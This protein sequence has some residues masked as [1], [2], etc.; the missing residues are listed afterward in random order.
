MSRAHFID[1]QWKLTETVQKEKACKSLAAQNPTAWCF[2]TERHRED[3]RPWVPPPALGLDPWF[4]QSI[5]R[6]LEFCDVK[7]NG[8]L[9]F[10]FALSFFQNIQ[11]WIEVS[12]WSTHLPH[13]KPRF[14]PQGPRSKAQW[15]MAV[16]L[17]VERGTQRSVLGSL[18]L[19]WA[20]QVLPRKKQIDKWSSLLFLKVR[21]LMK[22]SGLG[23]EGFS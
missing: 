12:G 4:L 7:K 17:A 14:H 23:P 10:P 6:L 20:T 1:Y 11:P 2:H 8:W 19:A 21:R 3:M 18:G 16:I 22:Y 5:P 9:S 15:C 13:T